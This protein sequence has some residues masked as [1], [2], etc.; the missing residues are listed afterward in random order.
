MCACPASPF[1]SPYLSSFS[2]LH[3]TL[4]LFLPFTGTLLHSST[5][6]PDVRF[7]VLTHL[8]FVPCIPALFSL[9]TSSRL[10]YPSSS[11]LALPAS[12]KCA[13]NGILRVPVRSFYTDRRTP[14]LDRFFTCLTY[15]TLYLV[16]LLCPYQ[17]K[18][19]YLMEPLLTSLPD[20]RWE[21]ERRLDVR[22][23]LHIHGVAFRLR[24]RG[25][26]V[27][28]KWSKIYICWTYRPAPRRAA[29]GSSRAG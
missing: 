23:V 6:S 19:N 2:I 22:Q 14:K 29:Q 1:S 10:D 15:F 28:N 17:V 3:D 9:F 27:S 25:Q 21:A 26:H 7:P 16:S 12:S 24:P 5:F 13:S 20:T 8:A 4:L 18:V 11:S